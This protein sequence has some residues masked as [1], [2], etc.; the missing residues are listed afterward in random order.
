M[1]GS[2]ASFARRG[3]KLPASVEAAVLAS[4]AIYG[5]GDAVNLEMW[6]G[7]YWEGT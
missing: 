6:R 4:M 3:T 1:A 5:N 2:S 7:G